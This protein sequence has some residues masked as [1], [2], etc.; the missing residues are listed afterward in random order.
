MQ[1]VI[2]CAITVK[3]GEALARG[4]A[5]KFSAAA[6][7]QD[8]LTAIYADSG[9]DALGVTRDVS[10]S[11]DLATIVLFNAGVLL[12]ESSATLAA[13]AKCYIGANGELAATGSGPAFTVLEAAADGDFVKVLPPSAVARGNAGFTGNIETLAADKTMAASDDFLQVLDPGGAGRNVDLP[14]EAE[15]LAY[16]IVNTADAAET[17]TVRE[18]AGAT[19]IATVA[20]NERAICY[21]DGPTWHGFVCTIT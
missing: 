21:C 13:G 11:G 8:P 3:A 16:A 5:V 1:S 2:S 4:R 20:Q 6:D 7:A 17:L 18:D 10:A 14:A 15:G 9:D 19:T 12:M